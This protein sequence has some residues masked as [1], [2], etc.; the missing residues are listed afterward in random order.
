[1]GEYL[2]T[3]EGVYD[4]LSAA[5]SYKTVCGLDLHAILERVMKKIMKYDF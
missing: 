1:M 4:I 3:R 2:F 5:S